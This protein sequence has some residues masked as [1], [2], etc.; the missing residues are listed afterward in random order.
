M[1]ARQGGKAQ[2]DKIAAHKLAVWLRGGRLP[3]AYGYPAEVR[4]PRDLLRRRCHLGPTRA[5]LLAHSQHSPSPYN[6][7][8]SGKQLADTANRA[9]VQEHCPD[10][11][12]G[13]T[14]EV[15][16]SLSAH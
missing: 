14:I 9:G 1:K 8:E 11:R 13:Q 12:V 16:V 6:L 4:A 3:H 10:P 15:E 2:N 7:P 5:E